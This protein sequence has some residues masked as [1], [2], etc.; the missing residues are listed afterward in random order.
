MKLER[1]PPAEKLKNAIF[2]ILNKYLDLNQ[3]KFFFCGSWA[4]GNADELENLQILRK[5]DF[6]NFNNVD[7]KF[8]KVVKENIEYIN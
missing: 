5:I 6:V 1:Y 3:Y 2:K 4:K 8:K 7:E